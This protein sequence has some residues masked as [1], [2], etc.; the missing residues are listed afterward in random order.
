LPAGSNGEVE[1]FPRVLGVAEVVFLTDK[2]TGREHRELYRLLAEPPKR[3]HPVDWQRAESVGSTF[4]SGP[5]EPAR[6]DDVPEALDSSK[7]LKALEKG[8]ADALYSSE[9]L[10]L[11]ENRTLE[12][13]SEPG[14]SRTAF[15][16]RCR[17]AAR[18]EAEQALTVER[19]K[20]APRFEALDAEVPDGPTTSGRKRRAPAS[21]EETRQGEKLRKLTA[22]WLAKQAEITER[23]RQVGEESV[24]VQVKPRKTDV[25]VTHFGLAW[26]PF[27]R[28]SGP[29]GQVKSVAVWRGGQSPRT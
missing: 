28:V 1:Y 9:K 15:Q 2:R 20:V 3:G 25:R 14:E 19:L 10:P 12:L 24:E 17:R 4:A 26:A 16:E 23:W 8:F 6:W 29:D 18:Q 21:R 11:F 22:D 27:V 7:K 5:A 13:V